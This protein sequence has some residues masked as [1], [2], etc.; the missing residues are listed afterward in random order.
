MTEA[1]MP[2]TFFVL[3][4]LAGLMVTVFIDPYIRREYRKTLLL[5]CG[6]CASLIVQN[7]LEYALAIGPVR[8]LERQLVAIYGY[9]VCPAIIVLIF[10]IIAP[11]KSTILPISWC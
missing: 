7:H 9:S 5:I 2:L 6:L 8:Q 10:P 1:N 3:F 4:L 11:K